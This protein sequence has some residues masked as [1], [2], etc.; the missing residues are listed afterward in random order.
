M[1][2]KLKNKILG[3]C[4]FMLCGFLFVQCERAGKQ[5]F[6]DK[7]SASLLPIQ[8]TQTSYRVGDSAFFL[9][10]GEFHYFRVPEKDWKKRMQ[11]FKEAGG[12]CLATYTPWMLHEMEEGK[13][14]FGDTG[15]RDLEKFLQTAKEAGLYVIVRPGPYQYSELKNGGLPD[16]LVDNYPQIK[17]QRFDGTEITPGALSYMH[18]LFLEK[19]KKWYSAVMPIVAKYTT[20]KGGPIA[21]IQVD[22]EL[23]GVQ[24]W[25]GSID[26]N[27]ETMGIGREGGQY[28]HFLQQKYRTIQELNNAYKT[29]YPAFKDVKPIEPKAYNELEKILRVKDYYDFYLETVAGY[30]KTLSDYVKEYAPK[31]PIIHNSAG[32]DMNVLFKETVDKMTGSQFVLGGDHYYN[33]G[34]DWAQNNPTP[35]YASR[36]FY[37]LEMLRL[38]HF[39][40]SVFEMPSGSAADWPPATARDSKACYFTNL[41]FGMKGL[42]YYIFTGGP[43]PEKFGL[44]TDIY[45]YGAPVGSNGEIRPLYDVQKEFAS[46]ISQNKWLVQSERAYDCRIAIDMEYARAG[47]WWKGKGNCAVSDPEAHDFMMKGILTT[48]LSAG[49]SPKFVDLCQDD[50]SKDIQTPVVVASSSSMSKS[51]QFRVVEFLKRGGKVLLAPVVPALDENLHPCTILSDFLG[52]PAFLPTTGY[53]RANVSGITNIR[54]NGLFAIHYPEIGNNGILGEEETSNQ[55]IAIKQDFENGGRL[56]LLGMKWEYSKWEQSDMIKSLFASLNMTPLIKSDNPNVWFSML[57]HEGKAMLFAINLFTDRMTVSAQIKG[58]G[59]YNAMKTFTL[60]PLSVNYYRLK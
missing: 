10:S 26:Y 34:Q 31:T 8:V 19:V 49:F 52:N 6:G 11:L 59:K 20:E 45:D 15:I 21:M 1:T 23:T 18:P 51:A 4:L 7:N 60:E 2:G 58:R 57:K 43:N 40:P 16:W 9:L 55:P 32:P 48:C 39:P 14:V 56:I 44:T 42:N 27:P 3:F 53:T 50:W 38:F 28:P 12:N 17:A 46:F 5:T 24:I 13:F 25:H 22:N 29:S 41:A 37:S 35:Q 54:N 36:I 47:Y 33:L 30:V